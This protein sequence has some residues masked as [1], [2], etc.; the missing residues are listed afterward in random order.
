MPIS[1]N[2]ISTNASHNLIMCLWNSLVQKLR[3]LEFFLKNQNIDSM[4]ITEARLTNKNSQLSVK[5]YSAYVTLHPDGNAKGG[6]ALLIK[7]EIP[8][9]VLRSPTSILSWSH[10]E[11]R[12]R[13]PENM[14][15]CAFYNPPNC[16]LLK[17]DYI[18]FVKQLGKT[19]WGSR[20]ITT[21]GR[22]ISRPNLKI[23]PGRT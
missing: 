5:D 21:K 15:V 11:H 9:S 8:H 20:M 23:I 7:K 13:D 2:R 17:E 12:R 3:E 1:K 10:P 6:T 18:S 22:R 14:T 4:L 16:P 19:L